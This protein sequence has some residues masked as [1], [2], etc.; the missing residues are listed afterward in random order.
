[1]FANTA[2]DAEVAV[3]VDN[4]VLSLVGC[5]G[6]AGRDAGGVVAV[7]ALGD[8]KA[9]DQVREFAG[10]ARRVN[11]RPGE[12]RGNLPLGIARHRAG[13]A[14]HAFPEIRYHGVSRH[15]FCSTVAALSPAPGIAGGDTGATT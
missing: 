14:A 6:R 12:A 8:V 3:D 10:H 13:L 9:G 1:M 2:A 4:T 7:I 11:V 5:A 15:L